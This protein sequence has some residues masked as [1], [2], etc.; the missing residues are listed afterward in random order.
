MCNTLVYTIM[1][2]GP[3]ILFNRRGGTYLVLVNFPLLRACANTC[4]REG[5]A[6]I[7]NHG[8]GFPQRPSW[9]EAVR[10]L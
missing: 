5:G 7:N 8:G 10:S 6:K 4:S 1:W 9:A 3:T 2:D